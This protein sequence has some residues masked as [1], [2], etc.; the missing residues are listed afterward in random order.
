MSKTLLVAG[1]ILLLSLPS[2]VPAQSLDWLNSFVPNW[3]NGNTSRNAPNV[4]GTSL[5]C[6]VS[7]NIHG[8]GSFTYALGTFG[9]QTPTVLGA[10][11]TVP[12]ASNRLQLTPN[13]NNRNSYVTIVMTFSSMTTNVSFRIAD[14]DKSDPNSD[15][16][17]DRVTITGDDGVATYDPTITR[18]NNTDP[19]F[20]VISGNTAHVNTNN[21][22]GG[23]ADSDNND[24]RGT[25]TVNFGAAVINTV[26][27]RYDNAP[28]TDNNP[29]AQAI[30]IGDVSFSAIALPVTFTSF[31][32][33]QQGSDVLLKWATAQE[34]NSESFK[35]ERSQT[36]S[37]WL[38]IGSVA[39]RG[40][41]SEKTDYSYKDINPPTT[42][43][44]Y[45]LKQVDI[46]GRFKYSSVVRITNKGIKQEMTTYPNPVI[47]IA[48]ISIYSP[49]DQKL[50]THLYDISGRILLTDFYQAAKGNNN[51]SLAGLGHLPAGVYTI[52][53]ADEN[54][55]PLG[56]SRL[57]KQ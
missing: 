22:E 53:V 51:F 14:I 25:I 55:N 40:T 56:V 32:G 9:A 34:I 12:G 6:D 10:T 29:A 11:F 44:F 33:A 28:G 26:T 54:N 7:A 30:A 52:K 13:F 24:Q 39:A 3:G 36:G 5:G 23:N 31:S 1:T 47:N 16:Y 50:S 43:L 42:T 21:G 57:I 20:L 19:D 35:V 27:I 38:Q 17:F 45:R 46:D 4:G 48:N 2:V 49:A 15:T 41:T 18:Y 37:D 8:G